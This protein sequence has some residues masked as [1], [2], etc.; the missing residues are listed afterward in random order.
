MLVL[1]IIETFEGYCKQ[2]GNY[3]EKNFF[4]QIS[5]SILALKSKFAVPHCYFHLE[6][7]DNCHD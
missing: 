3:G 2:D 6:K 4:E 7:A 5:Q 1:Y